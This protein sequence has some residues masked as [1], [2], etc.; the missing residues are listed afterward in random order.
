[1]DFLA[2]IDQ[3]KFIVAVA[4]LLGAFSTW[5]AQPEIL[6]KFSQNELVQWF[7]VFVLVWQGGGGQNIQLSL[8]VTALAYV[9]V[10]L[11]K[12]YQTHPPAEQFRQY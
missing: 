10:K 3:Q 6:K 8:L 7:F 9:V 11:L 1:M 4:T 2:N 12:R 5:P